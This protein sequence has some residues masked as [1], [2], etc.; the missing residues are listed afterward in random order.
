MSELQNNNAM[1][2]HLRPAL[3]AAFVVALAWLYLPVMKLTAAAFFKPENEMFFGWFVAPIA[4][5]MV[6]LRRE[7]LRLAI[8][9]PAYGGLVLLFFSFALL[10]IAVRNE[11]AALA[12]LSMILSTAAAVWTCCGRAALR[13]LF[14]PL[15]FLLF[16]IPLPFHE[17]LTNALAHVSGLA[18]YKLLNGVGIG[19]KLDPDAFNPET[20]TTLHGF[21]LISTSGSFAFQVQDVCSGLRSIHSITV[22]AAVYGFLHYKKLWQIFVLMACAVPF[23]LLANILRIYTMCILSHRY[24]K[25]RVFDLFHNTSGLVLFG[26]AA[27]LL[28][29]YGDK[30]LDKK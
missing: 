23:V 17:T 16:I 11:F 10:F 5:W 26:I 15:L 6:Y 22:L 18:S 2:K 9:N 4:F 30:W 25:E 13:V 21:F 7:Q 24:G 8:A 19:T 29:R 12:Q 20:K 28:I 14:F 3:A 27:L 1:K